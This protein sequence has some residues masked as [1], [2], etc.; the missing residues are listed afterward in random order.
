M[1]LA[2]RQDMISSAFTPGVPYRLNQPAAQPCAPE[3][4]ALGPTPN[5]M[6]MTHD[7]LMQSLNPLQHVPVLGMIYRLVTGE[8]IPAPM[9]VLGAGIVGGPIGA[10][11]AGFMGIME[12]VLFSPPDLSRPAV[13][14]GMSV[15]GSEAGVQPVTPGTLTGT[16]YTTLATVRPEWLPSTEATVML[17]GADSRRGAEAYQHASMEY[18][19]AQMVEKGLA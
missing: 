3:P 9:R 11:G 7:E 19:R 4:S 17:A 15:T 16:A 6:T 2:N 18:Q 13:P 10:L 12:K 8:T 14:A 1:P 5:S